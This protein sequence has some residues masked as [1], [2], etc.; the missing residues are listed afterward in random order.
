MYQYNLLQCPD[1]TENSM[2]SPKVSVV[3]TVFNTASYL[4]EAVESI[5]GQTFEDFEFIIV[6]DCSGDDSWKILSGYADLDPRIVLLENLS[7]LGPSESSNKGLAI[8]KGEYIA[9]FDSDDVSLA[10]RLEE[11][12]SYMETHPPVGLLTTATE[13]VTEE[14]EHIY[15]Y[16]PPVDP[17]LI[18]WQNVYGSPLRHPTAFWRR[19]L[20]DDLVGTYDSDFRYT[21]DYDFFSRS[22]QVIT[23]HTLPKI[24]VKMRQ[25]SSSISL[26][27]NRL[28]DSFATRICYRQLDLY[29]QDQPLDQEE[30]H[31]LRALLRR[32]SPLQQQEFAS[33]SRDRLKEALKNYLQLLENFCRIHN[34][35]KQGGQRRILHIEFERN[36]PDLM[37]HGCEN[38]GWQISRDLAWAYLMR[39]PYRTL[40]V[41]KN[42]LFYAVYYQLRSLKVFDYPLAIVRNIYY[43][44]LENYKA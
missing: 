39:Y 3:M 12:L 5:L 34:L 38:S 9:R 19:K 2:N 31:D 29:F 20:V 32:Y 42:L 18:K 13:H 7:N 14:G 24:L 4:A 36:L 37:R 25:R 10:T 6:D 44:Q 27:K 40:P 35:K 17:I 15:D 28:Q 33:L 22:C 8:A 1:F 21:L 41:L 30:K 23:V 43:R 11:Q 26:S 16:M